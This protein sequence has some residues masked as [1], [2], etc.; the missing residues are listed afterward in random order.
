MQSAVGRL[1]IA[2]LIIVSTHL[3]VSASPADEI[4]EILARA[5]ALYYEAD[6]GKS[7]EILSRADELLRDQPG[8]LQEKA[9]VKLQMALAFIGLNDKV[10]AKR[11]FSEMYALDPN[12]Q[13]DPQV[14]APKVIQL[15]EEAEGELS[16]SLCRSVLNQADEAIVKGDS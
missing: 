16:E 6:F 15:A 11:N 10:Q 1:S 13:M 3:P 5:Q 4:T 12:H 9:A 2:L 7:I 14:F 8:H